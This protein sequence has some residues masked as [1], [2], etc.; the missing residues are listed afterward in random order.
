MLRNR[1]NMDGFDMHEDKAADGAGCGGHIVFYPSW[2]GMSR[3][4]TP[5]RPTLY[6]RSA[7]VPGRAAIT[8]AENAPRTALAGTHKHYLLADG[9]DTSGHDET[10]TIWCCL[11]L[12]LRRM[13][14]S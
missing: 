1:Y 10:L 7:A 14:T 9:R 5:Y 12:I 6:R 4:S 13:E 8:M 3:P 11:N 2:L